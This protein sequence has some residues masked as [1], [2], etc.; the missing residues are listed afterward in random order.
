MLNFDDLKE[1]A[2]SDF[3]ENPK[4]DGI[5]LKQDIKSLENEFVNGK[6]VGDHSRVSQMSD[7]FSWK[8]GVVNV[9]TGWPNHG[10]PTGT[11]F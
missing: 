11:Q 7:Y 1:K 4:F 3:D 6:P 5:I 9:F 2:V 10:K 8:R